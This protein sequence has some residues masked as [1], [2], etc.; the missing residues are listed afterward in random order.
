M[1]DAWTETC[2]I[3]M[4]KKETALASEVQVNG[5][6]ETVD[7]DLGDKDSEWTALLNGGRVVNYTPMA[8]T[9]V[10]LD[11]Y[12][13]AATQGAGATQLGF[14]DALMGNTTVQSDRVHDKYRLTIL[15][16]DATAITTAGAALVTTQ[17]GLRFVGAEGHVT[18]VK[19]SMTDGRLKFTVTI[20]FPAFDKAGNACVF[21]ESC[22]TTGTLGALLT[23]T[24]TTY[25]R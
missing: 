17:T 2:L 14:F 19:P 12:C 13:V 21:F 16:T 11:C 1:V 8:D 6:T 7:I 23:Y 4:A 25:L 20:K 9:S 15:W 18:S 10:T 22:D 24:G 3:Q 5:V